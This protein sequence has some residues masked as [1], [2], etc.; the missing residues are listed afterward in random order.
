MIRIRCFWANHTLLSSSTFTVKINLLQIHK[1]AVCLKFG[2]FLSREGCEGQWIFSGHPTFALQDVVGQ[3]EEG[4]HGA[5][6]GWLQYSLGIT[7]GC[8]HS[9]SI[10]HSPLWQILLHLCIPHFNIWLQRSPQEM[11]VRWHGILLRSWKREEGRWQPEANNYINKSQST[12]LFT[13][14]FGIAHARTVILK[15]IR[16]EFFI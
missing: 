10:R 6:Q 16:T 9:S 3:G 1:T 4:W 2:P 7:Q 12:L 15:Y 8:L 13:P 14:S 5:I 11:S